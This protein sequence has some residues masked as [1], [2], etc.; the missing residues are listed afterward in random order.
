MLR[1]L[2]TSSNNNNNNNNNNINDNDNDNN[3]DSVLLFFNFTVNIIIKNA[4]KVRTILN[5][6]DKNLI[7]WEEGIGVSTDLPYDNKPSLK[8]YAGV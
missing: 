8:L 1:P 4:Q 2:Y 5:K 6:L 3:N 7:N